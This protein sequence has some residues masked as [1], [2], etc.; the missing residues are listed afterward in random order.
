[1]KK[2]SGLRGG[3][4]VLHVYSNRL[5]FY[6]LYE[7]DFRYYLGRWNKPPAGYGP[8]TVLTS[9]GAAEHLYSATSQNNIVI[10]RCLYKPSRKRTVFAPK[11]GSSTIA[12][13]EKSNRAILLPGCTRLADQI[14]LGEMIRRSEL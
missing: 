7:C 6:G 13:L 2:R 1:M 10:F 9:M 12:F 5:R 11:T 8:M 14:K 4:K 3:Y